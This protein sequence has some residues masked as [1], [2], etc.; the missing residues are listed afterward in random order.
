M[1]LPMMSLSFGGGLGRVAI[2]EDVV[3]GVRRSG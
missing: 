1:N 2:F 3:F